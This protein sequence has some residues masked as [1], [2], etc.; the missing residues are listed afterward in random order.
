M[1]WAPDAP[2][3]D[4]LLAE[5][6]PVLDWKPLSFTLRGGAFADYQA[7]TLAIRLCSERLMD[8]VEANRA[9]GD[10]VQWLPSTVTND[11]GET[12]AYFVLHIAAAHD[13]LDKKRTLFA[14]G[15][16]VVRACLDESLVA[17]H[18]V[19]GLPGCV[20]SLIVEAQIRE[21]LE[22]AGCTGLEFSRVL[23]ND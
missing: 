3:L 18:R 12:R 9:D 14:R 6:S 15:D 20:H 7:N 17:R 10:A 1:A 22:S 5:P 23:T 8:T 11:S 2:T 16:F 4:V 19:L 13:V 21:A